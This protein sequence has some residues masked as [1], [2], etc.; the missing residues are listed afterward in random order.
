MNRNEIV[1]AIVNS[2]IVPR[3][4]TKFYRGNYRED[5]VADLYFIILHLPQGSLERAYRSGGMT[6]VFRLVGGILK[7][8]LISDSSYIYVKYQRHERRQHP[9]DKVWYS[10][11]DDE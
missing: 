5:V 3:Y 7:R 6:G 10:G 11:T 4:A 2:D 8:Q 1:E 9:T